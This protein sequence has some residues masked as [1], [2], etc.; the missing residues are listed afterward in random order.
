[1][2]FSLSAC[3]NRFLPV[4]LILSP[5]R[6]G[7]PPNSTVC[8]YDDTHIIFFSVTGTGFIPLAL[9][10]RVRMYSGVVPQQPPATLTPSAI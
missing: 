9:S 8:V 4:G 7:D 10:V 1:M 3:L 6:T 5:I 2:S